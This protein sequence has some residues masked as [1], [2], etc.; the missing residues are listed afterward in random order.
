MTRWSSLAVERWGAC[1]VVGLAAATVLW[2]ETGIARLDAE[3]AGRACA[4]DGLRQLA[5][6]ARRQPAAP[7]GGRSLPLQ[8]G[9]HRFE[10]R[11]GGLGSCLVPAEPTEPR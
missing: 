11:D 1:T 10:W 6:R 3:L 5:E 7:P 9:G 2:L 8:L 4:Q